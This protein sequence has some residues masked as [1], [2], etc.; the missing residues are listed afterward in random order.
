MKSKIIITLLVVAVLATLLWAGNLNPS[1]PP[2]GGT[3]K[4]LDQVEPRIA[5][6]AANTPGDS[7]ALY[8]ISQPGSYY[9]TDNIT[10]NFKHAILINASDVTVDLMGYRI[11]SSWFTVSGPLDFDGIYIAAGLRNIKICNGSI[12]S[13]RTSG[14]FTYKGFRNGI[15][16]E[17]NSEGIVIKDIRISSARQYGI[18]LKGKG[19]Q[20]TQCSVVNC[21]GP[22]IH[23]GYPSSVKNNQ[24]N[25]NG[26]NMLLVDGGGCYFQIVDQWDYIPA[27]YIDQNE[28]TNTQYCEFLNEVGARGQN[29]YSSMEIVQ[30]GSPGSYTYTVV[31]GRENYPVRFVCFYEAK[32]Y[33][34]WKSRVTGQPYRLPTIQEW[35]KAAGWNPTLWSAYTYGFQRDTIDSTW[36]NYNNAYGGPLPVGSF[37]GTGGKNDAQSWYGCYDMSGNAGEWVI[38]ASD[39]SLAFSRGGSWAESEFW[40]AVFRQHS[41]NPYSRDQYTGFRLVRDC[42]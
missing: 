24:Q 29:Y 14:T 19:H 3:M 18:Y 35:E 36:C 33:A 38:D 15:L 6:N 42:E 32:A 30:S 26:D 27:F 8:I 11:Y 16:A 28:T 31:T 9:L 2:T 21:I 12:Q 37:N 4:P 34:E 41:M 25:G 1:A 23:A 7:T 40:C 20:V 39:L 17:Q 10:I 13:N 22:G 5:I